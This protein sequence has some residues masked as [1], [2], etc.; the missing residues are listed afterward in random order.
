MQINFHPLGKNETGRKGETLLDAARRA[1][2]PLANSCGA[3]G[4]CGRCKVR[5]VAG[6]EALTPP[7]TPEANTAAS[8]SFA[9]DERL[10]CQAVVTGDCT[11][12]TN[13]W[14]K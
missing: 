6:T 5:V 8:R 9:A 14:G 3:V 12:T 4:I 1:G 10:A 2:V 11:V 13:Y 7:T